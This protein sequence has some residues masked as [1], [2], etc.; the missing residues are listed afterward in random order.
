[1]KPLEEKVLDY[2]EC[3]DTT[4]QRQRQQLD[5]LLAEKSAAA[6]LIEQ[7]VE[8][9][10]KHE[11][12]DPGQR[13][14][15]AQALAD[16]AQAMEII[17]RTADPSCTVRPPS[18]GKPSKAKEAAAQGAEAQERPGLPTAQSY[19]NDPEANRRWRETLLPAG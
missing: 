4:I 17:L 9:L 1:M 18:I 5:S 6:A 13:A 14:K 2:I 19:L 11:R 3:A 10:V 7:V 8:Q 16:P 15:A 12:I